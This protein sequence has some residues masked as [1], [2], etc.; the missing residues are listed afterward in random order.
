MLK[1]LSIRKKL[2][3]S[4]LLIC[5]IPFAFGTL[6]IKGTTEKWLY[7]NSIIHTQTILRQVAQ[8]VDESIIVAMKDMASMLVLDENIQH[9]DADIN[10]YTSF[11]PETYQ[12]TSTE[13]ERKISNLFKSVVDTHP[14]VAFVSFGT[15]FGGYIEYPQFSPSSPYDPRVREWY[16]NARSSDDVVVSE[17]YETTVSKELVVSI[18]KKVKS[19]QETI[20]VVSLTIRLHDI[21]GDVSAIKIGTSGYVS[22]LSPNNIIINSPMNPDWILSNVHEM[23]NDEFINFD[24]YNNKS[25]EGMLNGVNKVFTLYI[26]PISGWK[27]VSIVDKS[28]ILEQS[29][30]LSGL[31]LL[32]SVIMAIIVIIFVFLFSSY[33]T[34]PILTL[35]QMIK[36]MA[37]FNFDEY[38]HSTIDEF[39]K[40][41]DEIGEIS[42]A[43][44]AM[45]SNFIE[46]KNSLDHMDSQIRSIQV[47]ETSIKQ[48]NLSS[49]NP[50][51]G[52]AYSINGLLEKVSSY[53]ATIKENNE[54]ISVKNDMLIASEEEL[55][56]QLEE[57]KTQQI[58]INFLAEHD[59][60][61]NLP[62]RRSFHRMLSDAITMNKRGAVI[63]LDMDNF[64]S[65]NDTL[66]HIFG[67]K[68]LQKIAEK[69]T[70]IST[71]NIFVSRFGGDE[72]LI[73]YDLNDDSESLDQYVQ[74]IFNMFSTPLLIDKHEIKVEFSMGI[75]K[76]PE[77]SIDF[78]QIIM[79]ADLALYHVKNTGKNHYAYFDKQMAMHLKQKLEI[80]S[81]LRYA[82]ENDGF[83]IVYQPQVA[84]DSGKIIGY[85]ALLR[86]KEH[87]ISPVEFIPVA[88][89]SGLIIPL[90]RKVTF[91]VIKQIAS[92]IKMGLKA[93]PIAIN[94][95]VLQLNDLEYKQ[96]LFDTLKQFNVPPE[97]IQIEITEHI[98][99]DNKSS[100]ISFM[101]DLRSNGIKIAVDDFGAEYSSL[102]YL[103]T[104][105]IDTLKFDR[106]MN[107]KLLNHANV[108]VIEKLIAFVHA[109]NLKI[110]AEGI[111][112]QNHIRLLHLYNCDVVQGYYF[113][114]PLEANEIITIDKHIYTF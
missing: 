69:L 84:L 65:I 13:N 77:D 53:L 107:L 11:A 72:F 86:F 6:Y 71:E 18:D 51:K 34:K 102:S 88:E 15:E 56:A 68:V 45:Q 26:S 110:V 32:I 109:L 82:L 90:G 5:L 85:E 74:T 64:K 48:L 14:F 29:R 101:N 73:A 42:S 60:L 52:I 57:I 46:L 98:F 81:N 63:L 67:D 38:E 4:M 79:Y 103:A 25:F 12:Y 9:V 41:K 47:E 1:N 61:T 106:E 16:I 76:F 33:I 22:I 43:L 104:L 62:N 66:G 24:Q 3:F 55:I 31:L 80:Q 19:D 100:A 97:L 37:N 105:P 39:S 113:S 30:E 99:L 114:K 10:N 96:F 36:K 50:F 89:E 40:N 2:I 35:S 83:K 58:K 23:T 94:F 54:E 70:T 17:P 87:S 93:K 95:S 28:E 75:S 49:D 92:W 8:H 21:M 44:G 91:M 59:P 27:Y 112:D 111:E 78:E 7:Q 20:G 108:E